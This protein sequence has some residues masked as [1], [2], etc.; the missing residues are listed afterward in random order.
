[1]SRRAVV[2]A[3]RA[4]SALAALAALAAASGGC[5]GGSPLLHPARVLPTGEVRAATGFSANVAVGGLSDGLRNARNEAAAN[6]NVPG[7]PGT[8]PTY[9]RG[10]LVAAAVGPGIAPFVAARVGVGDQFEGGIHYTGRGARIDMRRSWNLGRGSDGVS[11]SAGL[12]ATTL[13]YGHQVGGDLPNV[14]LGQ[15]R[16]YGLDVPLLIGW[17]SPAG[18]YQAWAGVRGGWDHVAI[19]IVRSEPKDF[20]GQDAPISLSATRFYGGGLVG[21][22]V[23]FRHVHVALELDVAYVHVD[24]AYNA[25]QTSIDGVAVSP[26][27]AV[28]WTF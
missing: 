10:A 11:L 15:L 8:D 3:L 23:G 13:F 12:G 22:A 27:S 19:E 4:W 14:D 16:G 1:V 9:A 5:A 7:A 28:W 2:A 26:A 6:P 20:T 17:D 18:I 24:G 25:T 21:F